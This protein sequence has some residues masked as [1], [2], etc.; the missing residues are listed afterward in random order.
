MPVPV[1]VAIPPVV[2]S[3]AYDHPMPIPLVPSLEPEKKDP[4]PKKPALAC[5]FCR[6][7]KIACGPPPPNS[8]DKTCNQCVRRKQV[9]EYPTE[10]RRG[11]RKVP[12]DDD[13][14]PT[15]HKFVNEGSSPEAGPS[16]KGKSR[17]K[18]ARE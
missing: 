18:R 14:Q 13:D 9:C 12:K 15:E 7:R 10:S 6:K 8:K 11:I 17:R 3:Q 16:G 2:P 1:P 5:L 4:P